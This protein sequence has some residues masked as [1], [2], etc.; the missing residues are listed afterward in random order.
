[1][2]PE[3]A[4]LEFPPEP[5]LKSRE[6]STHVYTSTTQRE[7][8]RVVPDLIKARQLLFDLIRKD[9]HARYRYAA[10]GLL[11]AVLEPLAFTLILTFVFSLVLVDKAQLADAGQGRPFVVMLLCGLIFWQFMAAALNTATFSLVLN[12]NLVKKVHFPRE[13]IPLAAVC[14]PLVNLAIGFLLL[15]VVH[16]IMGGR[17]SLAI[18]W[19]PFVFGI[20]FALTVGLA[21]LF[22][23]GHVRFRDIGN[24]VGVGLLFGFYAS[25][26]FYPLELVTSARIV[27]GWAAKLYMLNPMAELL[28]AYRQILFEQRF[29]D[30]WLLAWPALLAAAFVFLGVFVFRRTAPTFSDYL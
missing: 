26:V 27:P 30:L 19:F 22:S 13:V 20:Q 1:V 9:L 15:F 4:S 24:M 7:V 8:W 29:P 23:C 21:L 28:T 3:Q 18:L 10:M 11:W 5:M 25:P 16:L 2:R 12:F 6:M 14:F 17:L